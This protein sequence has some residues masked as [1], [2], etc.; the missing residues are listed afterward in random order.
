MPPN[1][2]TADA[3]SPA[4]QPPAQAVNQEQAPCTPFPTCTAGTQ[5][6]SYLAHCAIGAHHHLGL[7]LRPV[8]QLYDGPC[9]IPRRQLM[10]S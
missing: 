7:Q 1:R 8:L 9:G 6:L 2:R 4:R 5:L 3:A 10:M